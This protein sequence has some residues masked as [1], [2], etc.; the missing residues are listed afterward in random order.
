MQ[1]YRNVGRT[2]HVKDLKWNETY[3]KIIQATKEALEDSEEGRYIEKKSW[4]WNDEVQ[5]AVQ[6]TKEPFEDRKR[7]RSDEDGDNGKAG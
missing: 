3:P 4:W 7:T 5:R 2:K 1:G 6:N